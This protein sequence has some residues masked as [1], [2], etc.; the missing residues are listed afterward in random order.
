MGTTLVAVGGGGYN[1]VRYSTSNYLSSAGWS[2]GATN[3][4]NGQ[5]V[6]ANSNYFVAVN[7][8]RAAYYSTDGNNWNSITL[9]SPGSGGSSV[10]YNSVN[11][12]FYAALGGE[13]WYSA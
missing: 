11:G 5:G 3:I 10:A 2:T 8:S 4:G 12:L 1:G 13:L 9:T 7:S 6:V